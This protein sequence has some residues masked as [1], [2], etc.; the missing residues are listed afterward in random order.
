MHEQLALPS[1]SGDLID[2]YL[3]DT[4]QIE[5]PKYIWKIVHNPQKQSAIVFITLNNPYATRNEVRDFCTNICEEAGITTKKFR[6]IK[7]GYT[8]CCAFDE[9]SR[10]ISPININVRSLL[11]LK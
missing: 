2:L 7:K 3:S 5:V 6:E 1:A 10:T 9:F 11:K 8:N 4:N